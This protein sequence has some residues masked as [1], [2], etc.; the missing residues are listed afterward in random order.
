MDGGILVSHAILALI[1]ALVL[2]P[3]RKIGVGWSFTLCFVLGLIGFCIV[4]WSD[5]V[6]KDKFEE[7]QK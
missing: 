7:V 3:K 6:D 4:F 5:K 2:G 1:V